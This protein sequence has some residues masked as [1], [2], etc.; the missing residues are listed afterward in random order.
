MVN[1]TL[2]HAD[3]QIA[4]ILAK[5]TQRQEKTLML[6]PSENYASRAVMRA[7]GSIF[8]NKYAEGYPGKRYYNGCEF[9][10]EL[11]QLAIDRAKALFKCD[12]ANV[13][14]HTGSQAN[15]AAYYALLKPG[16]KI[17]AMSVAQGG[18][19]THGA[20]V[21]FSG[22]MYESHFYGLDPDT[23]QLNYEQIRQMA[24]EVRPKLLISGASAYPRIID[25]RIF[26]EIAD[27]VGALLM[28]DI[29]HICGL[30]AAEVHPNP[31]PFCDVVTSTT[32]KTL[33]GP[34]G[35]LMLCSA[36]WADKI[37]RAVFPGVQAGPLMHIIAG[38]AVAFKEAG[39]FGFREYQRQ[40]VRNAH[41]LAKTLLDEGF[42][43]VTGG[44]DNHLMLVDLRGTG[45][46]GAEAADMMEVAGMVV[47]K[48]LIPNDPTPPAV[49]S[50]IRP[51]TPGLTTRGM[52]EPEMVLVGHWI[53]KV[54]REG[55]SN[56]AML[57]QVR[58]EV[59]E[60]CAAFPIY[61]DL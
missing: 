44:T 31:V 45:V 51:G 53:A 18:H 4:A 11:E 40:I 61:I 3:P 35:A 22:Q 42:T 39:E 52:K 17:M 23:D 29:A 24:L 54:I 21:N 59:E 19:L 55:K 14:L 12:H 43:L 46:T 32:H 25:F 58:G 47:N 20:S 28:A 56:P 60:L 36:K 48:N 34:R 1:R 7:C 13:Q 16:D 50:G 57:D 49:T 33:R 41:T 5:E 6:I 8:T 37:D 9:Y 10:D 15:M 27:E 30:V 26:K 38:K 2:A